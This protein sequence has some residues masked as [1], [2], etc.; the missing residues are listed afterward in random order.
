MKKEIDKIQI[1]T[2]VTIVI[3]VIA[4]IILGMNYTSHSKKYVRQHNENEIK[5]AK[6]KNDYESGKQEKTDTKESASSKLNS[7]VEAGNAVAKIQNN[8]YEIKNT[9]YVDE[10]GTDDQK[11]YSK[12]IKDNSAN[13]KPYFNEDETSGSSWWFVSDNTDAV[14][15]F[16][17]TFSFTGNEVPSLWTCYNSSG[18]M[19]AFTTAIYDAKAGKFKDV[20]CYVTSAGRQYDSNDSGEPEMTQKPKTTKKPKKKVFTNSNNTT[21]NNTDSS[22]SNNSKNNSSTNNSASRPST[23]KHST[24]SSGGSGNSSQKKSTPKKKKEKNNNSSSDWNKDDQYTQ[25]QG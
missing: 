13:L 21:T 17:T 23:P 24:N 4:I 8:F 6:L 19:L 14:W 3:S 11:A 25:W 5:L 22:D 2:F 16:R 15:S 12:A 9:D 1:I 7:A 10:T 18:E 20:D